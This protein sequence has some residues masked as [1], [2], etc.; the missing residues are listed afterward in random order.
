MED[1][2][3]NMFSVGVRAQADLFLQSFLLGA[4]FC[5]IYDLLRIG[6]RVFRRGKIWIGVQDIIYWLVYGVMIF[7]TLYRENDGLV[8]GF[9][10]GAMLLGMICFLLFCS[11]FVLF[12][13]V[14]VLGGICLGLSKVFR[15]VAKPFCALGRFFRRIFGKSMGKC[16]KLMRMQK[17]RLKKAWKEVRM[18]LRKT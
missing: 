2:L 17:K 11:R 1:Y 18:N 14:K 10:I 16:K 15:I 9:A 3:N 6:R 8:R 13:G 5:F 4:F 12:V 7:L